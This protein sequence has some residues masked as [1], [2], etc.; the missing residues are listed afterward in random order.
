MYLNREYKSISQKTRGIIRSLY[1][2][3]RV[4]YLFVYDLLLVSIFRTAVMNRFMISMRY[5]SI[6]YSM[7][8]MEHINTGKTLK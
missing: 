4:R 6:I 7:A 8:I 5:D 2:F 3:Y 1:I